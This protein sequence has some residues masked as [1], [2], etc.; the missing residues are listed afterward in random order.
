[1]IDLRIQI[2]LVLLPVMLS[3]CF[4]VHIIDPYQ[5]DIEHL[6]CFDEDGII[7]TGLCEELGDT[8]LFDDFNT[9]SLGFNSSLWNLH[10]GNNPS[11]TWDDGEQQ[12]FNSER[13][14]H[15]T[16]ESVVST[17]PEVV[18]EFNLSF[19][20]GFSYFAI[21]WADEFQDPSDDYISNLRECQNGVFLDYWEGQLFV[22]S[23]H[24]GEEVASKIPEFDIERE[25]QY[26][27]SWSESLV[28]LYIDNIEQGLI[29]KSIPSGEC[30]FIITACGQYYLAD[31]DQLI[32]DCVGIYTRELIESEPFPR[33]SLIWPNL[34]I[35]NEVDI[36]IEG[37][38]GGGLYSWDE[39][40]NSSFLSPWDIPV[41]H[42]FGV[43][44]LDVYSHD[45]AGNWTTL[46]LIFTVI[47]YEREYYVTES[48]TTP[49]IDG[50]ITRKESQSFTKRVE[51][52]W[53]KIEVKLRLT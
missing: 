16:L 38:T 32:V 51:Y 34:F 9:P 39:S 7:N 43:H 14:T 23:C 13:L 17:G 53:Q 49:L 46:H 15:T 10:L 18:S 45:E 12:V 47:E 19:T 26:R 22:V 37:E 3:M 27:L 8:L 50:I 41:P 40:S 6:L 25:H 24:D 44:R 36:D 31:Y 11:L 28:R 30:S 42:S 4:G 1:M 29:S 52:L 21:G 5:T 33:I 2:L 35:F 48:Q 20:G